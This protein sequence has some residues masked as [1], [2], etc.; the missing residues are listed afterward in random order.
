M[1]N[2]GTY[3]SQLLHEIFIVVISIHNNKNTYYY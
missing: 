1:K 3:R 2:I